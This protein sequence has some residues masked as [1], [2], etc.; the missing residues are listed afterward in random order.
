MARLLEHDTDIVIAGDYLK[1][2]LV[3]NPGAAF[4]LHLGPWSRW[5]FTLIAI[6]AVYLLHR[7]WRGGARH[8]GASPDDRARRDR[9]HRCRCGGDTLADVQRRRHRRVVRRSG[10]GPLALARRQLAS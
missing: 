5:I 1:L 9:L 6:A 8:P 10:T 3:H 2:H 7:M 4:G